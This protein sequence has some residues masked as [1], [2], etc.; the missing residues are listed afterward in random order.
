MN[1]GRLLH[2]TG[3]DS[4]LLRVLIHPVQPQRLFLRAASP[5]LM[6]IWGMGI[7]AITLG[8][9]IF[10]D[11]AI[12]NGERDRLARLAIHELVHVRQWAEWAEE[13]LDEELVVEVE[14]ILA[15][16]MDKGHQEG[17]PENN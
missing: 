8:T 5:L 12:L 14:R 17:L 7:H 6:R 15:P 13:P 3:R 1:V 4:D 9:W 10:V 16:V 11:P 2:E